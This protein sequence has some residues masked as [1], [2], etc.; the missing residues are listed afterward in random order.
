GCTVCR[1][2][3]VKCDERAP[4]CLNCER[5]HLQCPG[6]GSGS[7]ATLRAEPGTERRRTYRSCKACRACKTRCSGERPV[8]LSANHTG[9]A[10]LYIICALGAKFFLLNYSNSVRPLP[11]KFVLSAGNDWAKNA[12]DIIF[13][14]LGEISI[15]NLMASVLIYDYDVRIGNYASAFMI[16]ATCTRMAQALQVNL[17]HSADVLCTLPSS[18]ISACSKEAR[19]RLMWSCYIMDSWVGS[20]VDQLTILDEKDIKIQLPC[21]SRNFHLQKPC[22]TETMERGK[23]LDFLLEDAIP[24]NPAEN[25]GLM[26]YFIRLVELRKRVLRYV[27]HLDTAASPWLPTSELSVL[28]DGFQDWYGT[29]PANMYYSPT[30]IYTRKESLE[31]GALALLWCTYHQTLCDLYRIGMPDLFKIRTPIEFPPEQADFLRHCQQTC[32]ENAKN[33]SIVISGAVRHGTN[34]LAD[35]W[36]CTIAYDSTRVML[37]YLTQMLDPSE[38]LARLLMKDTLPL[39]QANVKALRLMIPMFVT[40]EQCVCS[41]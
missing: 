8:W 13:A 4:A 24:D 16:S 3:K 35:T 5:L 28:A 11:A 33:V 12:K 37:Y 23:V 20:G 32:F 21:H 9:N 18:T 19:R 40:A 26:A 10:L 34:M 6:Y 30:S 15:E 27:K 39:L 38:D 29:L 36:M 17:E 31:L 7:G 2:R 22:I 41:P 25:M 1:A 14:D